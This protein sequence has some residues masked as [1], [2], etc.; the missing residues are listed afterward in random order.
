[1]WSPGRDAR[2]SLPQDWGS[3][4]SWSEDPK[5]TRRQGWQQQGFSREETAQKHF[6]PSLRKAAGAGRAGSLHR[7]LPAL[8]DTEQVAQTP[9]GT[10]KG[11]EG[12]HGAPTVME[13]G[14]KP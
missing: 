10:A 2:S 11:A 12:T 3:A 14:G 7:P 4:G 1:M 9:T 8:W 5:G 13:D 6:P